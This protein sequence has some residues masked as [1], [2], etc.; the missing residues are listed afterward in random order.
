M[1]LLGKIRNHLRGNNEPVHDPMTVTHA[2]AMTWFER[3][4]DEYER[5]V[6]AVAP[7]ID[8]D[9][10]LFDI[11]ANIGYF[12]LLLTERTGFR[13]TVYLFEPVP[14]LA[15]LCKQ[16]F[17][18][19]TSYRPEVLGFGL[20]DRNDAVECMIAGNGNIGWN[21]LITAGAD[22]D[23]QKIR[24]PVKTFDT[25]GITVTPTFIKIDVEGAEY[26]V[27]A[28]MAT[29]LRNWA[30]RPTILCE[31][32]WGRI[33][34]DWSAELAAFDDLARLGYRFTDLDGNS[35]II[36]DLECTTDVLC[37][38]TPVAGSEAAPAR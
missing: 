19:A 30:P 25:T 23:M 12:S 21:T 15:A 7:Y 29:S 24:V 10:A 27:L 13:G 14:H 35:I 4:R 31:V 9:G 5:L 26:K 32:G 11:G 36:A 20:S 38:P 1:N 6:S 28:G 18:K 22:A 2:D 3:R 34:P 33:H 17:A 37:L 8:V 16:T